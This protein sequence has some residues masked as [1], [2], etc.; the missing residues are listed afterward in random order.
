[1]AKHKPRRRHDASLSYLTRSDRVRFMVFFT[2]ACIGLY[3]ALTILPSSFTKP[4]NEHTA[5]TLGLVLNIL[6]IPVSTDNATVS[7]SSFALQIIPECTALFI[8]GFFLCFIAV[9]PATVRQKAVGLSMGIPI[10]YLGNLVRLTTIFMVSR[11]DRRLFEVAHVYL[12]QLFTMF[13]VIFTCV[14]WIEWLPTQES[15]Q[16]IPP[17]IPAFLF[18]FVL[19]SGPLFLVWLKVHHGYIWFIDRFMVFGFS[20]FSY[21]LNPAIPATA[22]YYETFNIVTF[23]SLVLATASVPWTKK[24]KGLAAGLGL[25]FLIHLFHRI[26]NAL[27][28]IFNF[29]AAIPV[30]LT[31]V[32]V[33][34]YLP[35]VLVLIYLLGR[36]KNRISA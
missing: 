30:D 33:G 20:L 17:K 2:I 7:D 24:I 6:G 18:R 34:Q 27:I 11:Y 29:T 23:T 14:L 12:G 28:V 32:V 16:R 31:L 4:V 25:F 5:W 10:L 19:I 3:A 1:M 36:Q 26:D 21:H 35:F 22:I 15:Q 8:V 13:L 9:Y